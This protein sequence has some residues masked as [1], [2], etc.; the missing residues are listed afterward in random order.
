MNK[1]ECL[2]EADTTNNIT[3]GLVTIAFKETEIFEK[4][5]WAAV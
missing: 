3:E 5:C 1:P 2:M 4:H